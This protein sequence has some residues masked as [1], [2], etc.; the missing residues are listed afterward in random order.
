MAHGHLCTCPMAPVPCS[1][2]YLSLLSAFLASSSVLC[3]P[4]PLAPAPPRGTPQPPLVLF[5]PRVCPFAPY[6]CTHFA[7]RPD[8]QDGSSLK[9]SPPKAHGV[10]PAVSGAVLP[11]LLVRDA[12]LRQTSPLFHRPVRGETGAALPARSPLPR[13]EYPAVA[14]AVANN[15]LLLTRWLCTPFTLSFAAIPGANTPPLHPPGPTAGSGR[16]VPCGS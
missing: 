3:A 14:V 7:A 2:L 9:G 1:P 15:P 11:R 16:A 13:L 5:C 6:L 4:P 12:P 8:A 10:P